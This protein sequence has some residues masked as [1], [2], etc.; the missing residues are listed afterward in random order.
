MII[1]STIGAGLFAEIRNIF[2]YT[3][4]H[5]FSKEKFENDVIIDFSQEYFPYKNS[6]DTCEFNNIISL[7]KNIII[8][9]ELKIYDILNNDGR[10]F[11]N[12]SF[13]EQNLVKHI[14]DYKFEKINGFRLIPNNNET[15]RQYLIKLNKI[16]NSI[17]DINPNVLNQV[18]S[19]YKENMENKYI[20]GIHYRSIGLHNCEVENTNQVDY[21]LHYKLV[22]NKIDSLIR[23]K[24]LQKN[25]FKIFIAT[26]CKLIL[27]YFKKKYSTN[28]LY[29]SNNIYMS[30]KPTTTIEPHFGFA[31]N[32]VTINNR[33]FMN[34][35]H[36]NKPGLNGGINLLIDVLLLAKSNIFLPSLSNVSD[37]VQIINPNI[38][39]TYHQ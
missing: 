27:H 14:R 6:I 12:F 2:H 16:F 36:K 20:I 31:L 15:K 17:F 23:E 5:Y 38:D 33:N 30:N 10:L 7:K 37:F 9:D 39:I 32:T 29:N 22:F 19:Y 8:D 35:F 34:D 3:Y 26:D 24:N 18:E 25:E 1:K 28:L 13:Y 4:S 11:F 21:H